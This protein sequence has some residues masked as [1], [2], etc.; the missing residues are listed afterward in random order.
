MAIIKCGT[1]HMEQGGMKIPSCSHVWLKCLTCKPRFHY[2]FF[3]LNDDQTLFT[4][5]N[6]LFQQNVLGQIGLFIIAINY[7]SEVNT[8]RSMDHFHGAVEAS[9]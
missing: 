3:W 6:W 1:K 4:R 8:A 7:Y 9:L 2:F 5:L